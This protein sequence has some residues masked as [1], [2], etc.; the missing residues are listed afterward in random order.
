MPDARAEK[1]NLLNLKFTDDTLAKLA[2]KG[3][4][5]DVAR[6]LFEKVGAAKDDTV[7]IGVDK[8]GP[9]AMAMGILRLELG[10]EL[11]LVDEKASP[12]PL[13]DRVPALRMGQGRQ[14]LVEPSPS[15]SRLRSTRTWRCSRPS[16][17]RCARRPTTSS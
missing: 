7:L 16:R 15:R 13:G 17:A 9:V 6:R 12:L 3:A 8:P 5:A 4:S 14:A 10:R 1:R 2:E 11:K